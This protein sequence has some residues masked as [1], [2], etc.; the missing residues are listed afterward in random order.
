MV[1]RSTIDAIRDRVDLVEVISRTVTLKRKGNTWLGLCPFHQEKS[2]SFNVVPHKG[3]YHCFGCGEGGDAFKFLM[4]TRGVS[5]MEAVRELGQQVGVHIEERELSPEETRVQRERATLYDVCEQAARWFHQVL[6]TRPE[7]APARE[8]LAKRGI[9]DDTIA[10]FRLGFAPDSWDAM[11]NWLH[12]QGI[13]AEQ[14]VAA[15]LARPREGRSGAYALFRGRVMIPIQDGRDRV[16]AFGG[17]ILA[18]DGPKYVNSPETEIYHKSKTLF[19]LSH[20]RNA[21]QRKGRALVVE[22]YFDVLSLHQ[23]GFQEAIAVCG[24]ALT[25]EHLEVISKLARR[26]VALFDGDAAG[27]RAAEK[28]L[29]L[30]LEK[31][32]EPLWLDLGAHKDP[33]EYIQAE[34]PPGFEALLARSQPLVH[35]IVRA[36]A[37][38]HGN[39]PGGRQRALEELAPL[40]AQ[41]P[42]AA[43]ATA[44]GYAAGE[45]M[46]REDVLHER[47]A[48]HLSRPAE[49]RHARPRWTGTRELNHLL[50]LLLHHPAEVAPVFVEMNPPP[51]SVTDHAPSQLA[52]ALLATGQP[53][54]EVL[55]Q[56]GDPDL[57]HILRQAAAR[58]GLYRAE[59]AAGAARQ[60][61][62]GMA[63]KRLDAEILELRR[64]LDT[65]QGSDGRSNYL[66]LCRTL[67]DL[68][69]QKRALLDAFA[70]RDRRPSPVAL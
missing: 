65:C 64:A 2:P 15:G 38:A 37:S 63:V 33:D 17:R 6:L 23:A 28:S 50:W 60:I 55:E 8:Y 41:L 59:Q 26:V 5:F 40:F 42:A 39:S 19:A 16:V 57:A 61:L 54:P 34:G 3:I 13:D 9:T 36:K 14:A 18:G 70:V 67:Q 48:Q 45:L 44:I 49:V 52:V 66:V 53:L 10:K 20:A 58:E 1:Q 7:A 21:I 24:T 68:Q 22:G 32:V 27:L 47:V 46:L 35:R 62:S 31:D 43:R 69:K 56:V 4:K 12:R 25:P 51:D 29:G 11:L 30:F